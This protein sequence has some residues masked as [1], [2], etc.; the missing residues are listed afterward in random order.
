MPI[1]VNSI[2]G[3]PTESVLCVCNPRG[4]FSHRFKEDTYVSTES[5]T[6]EQ[7]GKRGK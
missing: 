3:R 2:K 5:G 7:S 6:A 4:F 1:I